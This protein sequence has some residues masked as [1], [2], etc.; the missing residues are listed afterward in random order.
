MT[1]PTSERIE[2]KVKLFQEI[3]DPARKAGLNDSFEALD[4]WLR[5]ALKDLLTS[6]RQEIEKDI[7][8]IKKEMIGV[9][10]HGTELYEAGTGNRHYNQALDD[11]LTLIRNK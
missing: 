8:D 9:D 5:A 6:Q 11:A 2:E 4:I 1:T 7:E 3:T 10:Q